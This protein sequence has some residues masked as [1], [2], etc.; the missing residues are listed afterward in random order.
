MLRCRESVACRLEHVDPKKI[1]TIYNSADLK[2]FGL[3]LDRAQ[4]RAELGLG[5]DDI[6]VGSA[7]RLVPIK[8]QSYFL[9]ALAAIMGGPESEGAY[10]RGWAVKAELENEA[11]EL[12]IAGRVVFTGIRSDMPR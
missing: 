11:R 3:R 1:E 10:R 6:V 8:G 9:K 7:S 2:A 12:G 4:V 5:A